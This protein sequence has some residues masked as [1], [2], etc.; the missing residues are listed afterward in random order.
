MK[1]TLKTKK[2]NNRKN[3]KRRQGGGSMKK[4][5]FKFPNCSQTMVGY[6]RQDCLKKHCTG[7]KKYKDDM[8]KLAQLNKQY[9][10]A[11]AKKCNI[12][13]DHGEIWPEGDEQWA[14]L[15]GERKGPL[16]QKIL[17]LEDETSIRAC[18]EKHC[19]ELDAMLTVCMDLGEEKCR[20][21]YKDLIASVEKQK[22]IKMDSLEVCGVTK[23]NYTRETLRKNTKK[24]KGGSFEDNIIL[25]ENYEDLFSMTPGEYYTFFNYHMKFY[26]FDNPEHKPYK[27]ILK[28][29]NVDNPCQLSIQADYFKTAV[30]KSRFAIVITF[31]DKD[32]FGNEL[33]HI[34]SFILCDYDTSSKELYVSLTCSRKIFSQT[35]YDEA[36]TA[37]PENEGNTE[38]GLINISF[39]LLLRCIMLKYA[40]TIGITDVYNHASS[41]D[42]IPYYTR[43]GFRLGNEKCGVKD[44]ITENHEL[45]IK[46][47]K[48]QQFYDSLKSS[49]TKRGFRMK[50]CGNE[51][52][53]MCSHAEEKLGKYWNELEEYDDI[54]TPDIYRID[55]LGG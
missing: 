39:G 48:T 47:K 5:K 20:E 17:K 9:D 3:T 42:L 32:Y 24:M 27:D 30:D 21:K 23:K 40:K 52:D 2:Y 14:C 44:T 15:N 18:E 38:T 37:N 13:Q 29:Q 35:K 45:A 49:Q 25:I 50:L 54:Y 31:Y 43:F 51:Y 19:A 34:D 4:Q 6:P 53:T 55:E 28:K 8:K 22:K 11:V 46:T 1:K 7:T 26:D 33:E 12:K 36:V 16:F 41:D 10:A